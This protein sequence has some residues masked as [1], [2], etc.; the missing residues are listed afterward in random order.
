MVKYLSGRQK[1]RPQDKLTEDR[2]QYLGLEQ[3]E[4]NLAD[5][6]TSPGVPAGAQFQLIAVS[7]YEGRRYWVPVGGGLQ[8]GAITVFDEGTQVSGTSSITQFNFVGAAVTAATGVQSP[9]GHPGIAATITVIPVTVGDNPPIGAGTTNN[10]ELWWESD[11]GDLYVYYNDGDSSQWVMANSGGRGLTGDKGEQG[12]KGEVGQKGEIGSTGDQGNKGDKGEPST[13]KGNTG[14]KG[15]TGDKGSQG[16]KGDAIKGEP[17][18]KGEMNVINSNADDRVITG[19]DTPGELNAESKL[20]FDSDNVTATLNVTGNTNITGITTINNNLNVVNN[21]DVDGHTNLDNVSIT[22]ITTISNTGNAALILDSGTGNQTGDQVSFIDFFLNGTK[23]GNVAVNEGGSHA[24]SLELNSAGTGSTKLF[25]AG[26][27]KFETTSAG[28]KVNGNLDVTG[29]LTY[30]DVTNIDSVGIITARDGIFV[31]DN[32]AIHLGNAAGSGDL[33]IFHDTQNSY[34]DDEGT[35][36]LQIRTVNGTAINLIGGGADLTDY[37]ARFVKDGEASLYYNTSLKFSTTN[38]GVK[39]TGGLQDKDGE[40]G[41]SGQVLTSTGTQLNWVAATTVGGSVDTT[42]AISVVDGTN[43]DE[44]RIRLT[45]SNGTT[46]DVTLEAGSGLS[47]ARSGDKITFTNTDTGSAAQEKYDLLVPTGTTKIRLE[48]NTSSGNVNDDVE[49]TGS[50]SISVT[51]TNQN[52]LTISATNTTY[53]LKAQQTSGND[54]DP[55]IFLDASGTGTD[56]TIQL[57]GG[58]NVS[59]TRNNDGQITF[60]AAT[61]ATFTEQVQDIVGAMFSGNTE[62]R[63]SATYQDSD[64]TIDLVVDDQSSDNNTTY[65]LTVP[66]STTNIRLAGNDSTN[67]DITIT[68]GNN[69]SVT[70]TS[71]TELN[72]SSSANIDVTQL[73]LNRIRFGPGNAL[74]DDANIEWLGGNNGG[75][76]RI[77]TSDDSGTEYIELGDYSQVNVAGSFTQW[78]TLKRDEFYMNRPIR[79]NSTLKDAG[80]S[81]GTNGQVLVSTGTAVDWVNASTVGGSVDNYAD[82]LSFNSG[83]LTLGRTGSLS[84]LTASIPL[85]GITGDFTDLDDTPGNYSGQANKLVVVNSS[86]NGLTFATATSVATDNYYLTGLS[87]DTGNGILTAT[88]SG[89]SDQSV[90]LDGR[91]VESATFTASVPSGSRMLFQQSA[92]PTGWTKDTSRNNRALRLVSGNVGDGGGNSFTGVFNGT[93]TTNSGSVHSHTLSTAQIPAHFHYVFRS[94]NH[95]QNQ[96]GSNL[97]SNNYPGSGSGRSN[98]YEGYNISRS[99]SQPN[100]GRSQEIGSSQGHSHGFTNPQFNLNVLYTDVIICTKN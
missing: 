65:D 19:S 42:Y 74:N 37:M 76:L 79:L 45:D 70:R 13:V 56:D 18:N 57:V 60:S 69:I 96:N 61:D 10:G 30:E 93:V 87:F 100:V 48:G 40:L 85:S 50:G 7:G 17:G 55:N 92:A 36:E 94:G 16:D 67:D 15:A 52:R 3:A 31:P 12:Q 90:D 27:L 89:A 58:T 88:V 49:I 41:T 81:P 83:T 73:D 63:I 43:S 26:Q 33:R 86:A 11:T 64:G 34:I 95:G 97:S 24:G 62:T 44:E 98:L 14:D 91:Y 82:S 47:I 22:G 29:V 51:R 5:P 68:G 84:D 78:A 1:R 23:R 46:D 72:I 6:A 39:I 53:L 54:N 77:S 25:D 35:G 2:Y 99:N 80:N 59:I 66:S 75:Y 38:N 28:A 32:K 9:S 20:T 8:P 71:A 21:F 4:P